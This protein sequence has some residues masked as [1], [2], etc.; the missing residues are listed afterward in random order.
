MT[1]VKWEKLWPY[2]AVVAVDARD[3]SSLSSSGMQQV[4][5]DIQK[6]LADALSAVGLSSSW[7][8]RHFGQHTGDGYVAGVDPE[9]LP[10]LVGCFPRSLY[11]LLRNRPRP[12][13]R[14]LQ[15][16]VSVHVGPL[17]DSG[18]GDPMVQTHRLL[19]EDRLR[20][21]LSRATPELTPMAMIVSERAYEDVFASGQP[22]GGV[23]PEEFARSLVRV[24][25][26]EKPAWVHIP[27]LD[28][29]LA[30][31]NLLLS[32]PPSPEQAEQEE[33]P[34]HAHEHLPPGVITF[35]SKG[36]NATQAYRIDKHNGGQW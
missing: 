10:A 31:P 30:D 35:N 25:A 20:Q 11:E 16:R 29:K 6:L 18:I 14:P 28:W 1:N 27:G 4:N 33:A 34:R 2:R 7:R 12:D 9:Y 5:Q 8:E 3:F 17:P 32:E 36:P 22:T 21:L 23:G 26:F 19:D 15:L 13:G 24:K